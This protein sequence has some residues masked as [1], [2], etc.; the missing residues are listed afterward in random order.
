MKRYV[1]IHCHFYQP[2]REN[3]WLETVEVEDSAY[4]RHDWNERISGE[5]YAPNSLS[6][7]LD[8]TG[9]IE[10]IV[11]NYEGVS[12][13][14]GPTLLSWLQRHSPETYRAV[15]DADR[16]SILKRSGHGNAMAQAYNHIILP[17]ANSRDK[18]TQIIWGMRDFK[19]RFG[20]QA[21]GMWLPETAVDLESLDIMA[22]NG[23]R[24]TVL[25][26]HQAKRT[27]PIG[28]KD[29]TDTVDITRPYVVRLPSGGKISVFFYDG[30][31][32]R[33]VAF[34]N[35]L[36]SGEGFARRVIG[37]FK[38]R[39]ATPELMHIATDGESYGHHHRFGDMALAYCLHYI[40]EE[41]LAELT[42]YGQY[43]E[44][45]PPEYEAEIREGTSW[46]CAHGLGRWKEDC[47]C[48]SGS[49]AGWNQKWRAPLREALDLLR[50]SLSEGY[51]REGGRIFADPWLARNEYIDV[52]LDRSDE[53]I[54]R[55]LE[56]HARGGSDAT[57]ALK[58]LE[59]ERHSM[60]MYTS[61]GWFFDDISG[62]E[63]VQILKYAARAVQL[64]DELFQ[65]GLE[66][67]FLG[68]LG[69]AKSNIPSMGS[70]A[71]VYKRHVKP[72]VTGLD[73]VAVHYAVSS[74]FKDYGER[75]GVYSYDVRSE[76]YRRA[77]GAD[78]ALAVG[79]ADVSSNVTKERAKL[80]F[81]VIKIGNHDI[82]SGVHRFINEESYEEMKSEI[83]SRFER[84]EV[85]E[86]LNL[87]ASHFGGNTYS[88]KELFRDERRKIL[89]LIMKGTM[90]SF[91]DAYGK[92]YEANKFFMGFLREAS[93]PLPEEFIKAAEFT[94]TGWL[95]EAV[96]ENGKNRARLEALINE[97]EGWGLSAGGPELETLL[98][99][100]L[101]LR[102]EEFPSGRCEEIIEEMEFLIDIARRA[103]V[104]INLWDVQNVYY[105]MSKTL[106]PELILKAA[107][108]D[109]DARC[110]AAS[111]RR[112]GEILYFGVEAILNGK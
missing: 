98:W 33:A 12:F 6:R 100:R 7:I 82:K 31:V 42:N 53:G 15:L 107:G 70:G 95:T 47:G 67:K 44:R 103:S 41:K 63:A 19:H 24:F 27:R 4:P 72:L 66:E 85:S 73:E 39:K 65:M 48:S 112:L 45:H 61:C 93:M 14:F 64:S 26:E 97:L 54:G 1:A 37:G 20:R 80:D 8:G 57:R 56:R 9:R 46:S 81:A 13:D 83:F 106:Y 43:L 76:D 55:F 105:G 74:L 75:T 101:R 5:C 102:M 84:G 22:Q 69:R 35:L 58:L 94:I 36:E 62:I 71:D 52:V 77:E 28:K 60:L 17:L 89:G 96:R 78:V 99:E 92:L 40:E 29:W 90:E 34:E 86:A 108:G 25:S 10:K 11:N 110:R 104:E 51:E 91:R 49:H 3:P 32:S 18:H 88:L 50:D 21:E 68:V 16:L 30:A 111:F 109:E 23:I 79:R 59:L 38:G 2:P 87:M